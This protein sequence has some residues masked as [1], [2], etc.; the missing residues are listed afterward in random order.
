MKGSVSVAKREVPRRKK[1]LGDQSALVDCLRRPENRPERIAASCL[2][3]KVQLASSHP[4][5][6]SGARSH[7][8]LLFFSAK[9]APHQMWDQ[10]KLFLLH[11]W[12]WWNGANLD[13]RF[14]TRRY[15]QLVGHDEFGNA[16]YRKP[17]IDP[18]LGFERDG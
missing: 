1:N 12:T 15:G 18:A 8:L 3:Q 4:P 17:G 16:Y 14:Y 7:D 13:T 5:R 10:I 6:H 2:E 11:Y 9:E